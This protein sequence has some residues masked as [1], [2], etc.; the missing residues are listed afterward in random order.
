MRLR[1]GYYPI[2]RATAERLADTVAVVEPGKSATFGELL[3]HET[4]FARQLEKAAPETIGRPVA[5]L[6]PKSIAGVAADL[7]AL[8]TGNAY[9]NLDPGVPSERLG[10][11]L[12]QSAPIAIFTDAKGAERLTAAG[13]QGAVVRT[14]LPD[15]G[16]DGPE[17]NG[18]ERIIDTDPMCLINTSG[19]TGTPK[20]VALC[21]RS[22][23][24]FMDCVEETWG[25]NAPL[26][27]GSLS[28]AIFDIY[29]FELCHLMTYGTRLALIPQTWAMFPAKILAWMGEQKVDFIFWVPTIMVNMANLGLLDKMPPTTL[30]WVWFAGE[31]FPTKQFNVWRAALPEARFVNLYGPI[32][33]TL[34]CTW[35][36]VRRPFADSEPLPI[37]FPCRNTDV[38][39]LG[40]DDRPVA[41][42]EEGELCVR[43]S[44]LALGYYNDPE[45]TAAAFVQNP[46]QTAYP[47]RIYRTGDIVCR[48]AQGEILFRG[49]RDTLV[50][51]SGYRIELGEVEHV[52]LNRLGLFPNACV[53][54]DWLRRRIVLWYEGP[55][56]PVKELRAALAAVLPKYMIPD[57]FIHRDPLPRGGTGKI[58]R[59]LLARLANEPDPDGASPHA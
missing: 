20:C 31:V 25:L 2:F 17:P 39:I 58:D 33:I 52:A 47:E 27:M 42:G 7:A 14:D 53:V 43:G 10:N 13:W 6:L 28:P 56:H 18:W 16:T 51:H 11:I 41:D 44:S 5:V 45:K 9:M 36:E 30:R 32:E 15:E 3:A 49:R 26:T 21:H 54:Y 8:H 35:Y 57:H 24:D 1:T 4:A 34:D 48:N 12:R 59:A 29:S 55:E 50:K 40:E 38:L 46:L 37:G 19:S 23:F 22:F